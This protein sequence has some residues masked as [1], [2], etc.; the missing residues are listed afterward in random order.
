MGPGALGAESWGPES[1]TGT[2]AAGT[3]AQSRQSVNEVRCTP[4]LGRDS[5]SPARGSSLLRGFVDRLWAEGGPS[6]LAA[7][8]TTPPPLPQQGRRLTPSPASGH[9][10]HQLG[11][12]SKSLSLSRPWLPVGNVRL[13][14][15][16][17]G[18]QWSTAREPSGPASDPTGIGSIECSAQPSPPGTGR[19]PRRCHPYPAGVPDP[20]EG[21][22]PVARSAEGRARPCRLHPGR[23][24][25]ASLA[26]AASS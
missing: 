1:D 26:V 20:K 6:G 22:V 15:C 16:T 5:A 25:R 9:C 13:I 17:P 3:S 4:R 21:C 2:H 12:T 19:T 18:V 8:F 24:C 10:H 14:G 23:R 11:S 7:A